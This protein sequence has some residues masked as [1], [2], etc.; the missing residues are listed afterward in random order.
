MTTVTEEH[1]EH[2]RTHGWVLVKDLLT[3]EDL[4]ARE[5]PS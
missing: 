4:A 2:W 3:P 1:Y 5:N